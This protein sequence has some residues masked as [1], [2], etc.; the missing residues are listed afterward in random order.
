MLIP[1]R[2][3]RFPVDADKKKPD[4]RSRVGNLALGPRVGRYRVL[5]LV[6][7][8]TL[9]CIPSSSSQRVGP[10][11]RVRML[12]LGDVIDQYGGY[13]SFTIVRFDPAISYTPVPSRPDYVTPSIAQ[14]NLRIYM[15]GPISDLWMAMM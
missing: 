14:R 9:C 12:A 3:A 7:L 10:E 11:G 4:V 2:P 6:G 15:P 8:I 1:I 5:F 13:N